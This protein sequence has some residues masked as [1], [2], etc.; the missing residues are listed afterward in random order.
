MS[1][2]VTLSCLASHLLSLPLEDRPSSAPPTLFRL[3]TDLFSHTPPPPLV[4]AICLTIDASLRQPAETDE[5]GMVV[6]AEQINPSYA[7]E[8]CTPALA[9]SLCDVVVLGP[10]YASRAVFAALRYFIHSAEFKD[11]SALDSV[12]LLRLCGADDCGVVRSAT[13]DLHV[14]S[15]LSTYSTLPF[16]KPVFPLAEEC[17]YSVTSRFGDSLCRHLLH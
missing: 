12:M 9:K 8:V 5:S 6:V 11:F 14:K 15:L 13:Q 17:L 10:E 4:D 1:L 2:E 7:E 3:F 16:P